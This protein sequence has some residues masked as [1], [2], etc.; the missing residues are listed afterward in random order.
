MSFN[1]HKVL[2]LAE[3]FAILA[4]HTSFL[5]AND[6]ILAHENKLIKFQEHMIRKLHVIISELGG[7]ILVLKDRQFNPEMTKLLYQLYQQL[8]TIYNDIHESTPYVGAQE[9]IDYVAKQRAIIDNLDFLIKDH[10][11]KTN[12]HFQ[13]GK[14]LQHPQ[15]KSLHA[16]PE[17]TSYLQDFI[18]IN[19]APPFSGELT[20]PG[21]RI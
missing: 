5:P 9:L 21:K 3:K 12:D 7:E 15:M 6:P 18:K 17:L 20:N 16:L 8:I 11:N 1:N 10:L 19:P 2:Q 4:E 13:T 14:L